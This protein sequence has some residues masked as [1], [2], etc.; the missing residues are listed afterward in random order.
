MPIC[1][2]RP[3]GLSRQVLRAANGEARVLHAAGPWLSSKPG[4]STRR[5][6][7]TRRRLA[8]TQEIGD[9]KLGRGDNW[10]N[11]G[12]LAAKQG[13]VRRAI[14]LEPAGLGAGAQDQGTTPL[15]QEILANLALA[16]QTRRRAPEG[17]P[18]SGNRPLLLARKLHKPGLE[19]L[20]PQ[21]TWADLYSDPRG[22]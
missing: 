16:Y 6:P 18:V 1:V 13:E 17:R 12:P 19:G 14:D 20:G 9:E 22:L 11:M 21:T 4:V 3:Y 5:R 10:E 7:A 8:I 2:R 15:N